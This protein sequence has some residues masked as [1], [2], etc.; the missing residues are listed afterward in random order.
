MGSKNAGTGKTGQKLIFSSA[1]YPLGLAHGQLFG[2]PPIPAALPIG[3]PAGAGAPDVP[4][5]E[6]TGEGK[7]EGRHDR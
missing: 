2:T 1:G 4:D 3:A 7:E 6:G 5:D